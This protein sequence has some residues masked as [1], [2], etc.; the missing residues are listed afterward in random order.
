MALTRCVHLVSDLD[1]VITY[2]NSQRIMPLTER[3]TL[4]TCDDTCDVEHARVSLRLRTEEARRGC[5]LDVESVRSQREVCGEL[6][7]IGLKT[8]VKSL[9]E[10]CSASGA[11]PEAVDLVTSSA[12]FDAATSRDAIVFDG[13]T[14]AFEVRCSLSLSARRDFSLKSR[15]FSFQVSESRFNH[16]LRKQFTLMTWMKHTPRHDELTSHEKQHIVCNSDGEGASLSCLLPSEPRFY[17]H[18]PSA[19]SLSALTSAAQRPPDIFAQLLAS[20]LITAFLSSQLAKP[21]TCHFPRN[22]VL[23]VSL[24][25]ATKRACPETRL[26][27]V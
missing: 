10:F 3:A 4:R 12:D 6:E 14:T 2:D 27:L 23:L 17:L 22:V 24:S 20:K 19:H 13:Q 16:T 11:S 8:N 15:S 26:A 9:V 7:R 1:D 25:V 21:A 5:D 18:N